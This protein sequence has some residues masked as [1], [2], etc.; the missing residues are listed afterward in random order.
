MIPHNIQYTSGSTNSSFL[1]LCGMIRRKWK[2]AKDYELHYPWG[3]DGRLLNDGERDMVWVSWKERAPIHFCY[4]R[5]I[6]TQRRPYTNKSLTTPFSFSK[7]FLGAKTSSFRGDHK[8]FMFWW[9]SRHWKDIHTTNSKDFL[10]T[11]L[12]RTNI[13]WMR[14]TAIEMILLLCTCWWGW[15]KILRHWHIR[16]GGMSIARGKI[17]GI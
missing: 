16:K 6:L 13:W 4:L 10:E 8:L 7:H 2:R 3:R 15:I 14:I 11:D 17:K 1:F 5:Y 12:H 9:W